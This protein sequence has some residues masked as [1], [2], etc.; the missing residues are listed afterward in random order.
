M[1]KSTLRQSMAKLYQVLCLL[2]KRGWI[3]Y[4]LR[5]IELDKI[6]TFDS[7]NVT[8]DGGPISL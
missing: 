2:N 8:N 7:K 3:I 6:W 4:T 1:L 5:A